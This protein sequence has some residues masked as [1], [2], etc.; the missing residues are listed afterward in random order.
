MTNSFSLV[1]GDN[2]WFVE[3]SVCKC[4]QESFAPGLRVIGR[5]SSSRK[6]VL[7][8]EE[9]ERERRSTGDG[10]VKESDSPSSPRVESFG[11][12]RPFEGEVVGVV[13]FGGR[14]DVEEVY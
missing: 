13:R 10:R 7:R 4:A 2:V 3:E 8:T 9:G 5:C 12:L 6:E 14:G 1:K 11:G